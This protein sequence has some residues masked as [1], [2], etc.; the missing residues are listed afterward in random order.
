M[1]Q[2]STYSIIECDHHGSIVNTITG[3]V[4]ARAELVADT[5][6]IGDA[7]AGTH[8]RT[9][10][11]ERELTAAEQAAEAATK[12]RETSA[13]RGGSLYK[14]SHI[15]QV[16]WSLAADLDHLGEMELPSTIL[17]VTIQV[18]GLWGAP[19][20]TAQIAAVD[21]IAHALGQQPHR[22]PV[23]TGGEPG[24]YGT[25]HG[26][27]MVVTTAQEPKPLVSDETIAE[28]EQISRM[29]LAMDLSLPA[30][31][32]G[33]PIKGDEVSTYVDHCRAC[34]EPF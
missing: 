8:P 23:Q 3:L 29:V 4:R 18:C 31:E 1:T 7:Y 11:I 30:A 15:K 21:R 26:D 20:G 10:L 24:H 25:G 27:L 12:W 5:L 19:D 28:A 9:C 32:C 17:S 13:D 2:E 14:A 34:R 33:C 22:Y 16:L 6:R